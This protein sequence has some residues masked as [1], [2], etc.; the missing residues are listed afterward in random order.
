MSVGY[1]V[2][3]EVFRITKDAGFTLKNKTGVCMQQEPCRRVNMESVS[4]DEN[5]LI[6]QAGY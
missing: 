2:T 5:Q 6:V 4:I 1:Q 3:N